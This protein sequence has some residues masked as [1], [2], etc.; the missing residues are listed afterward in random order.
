[1]QG[2]CVVRNVLR[3]HG[4]SCTGTNYCRSDCGHCD[5]TN[6]M[7]NIVKSLY[8]SISGFGTLN[9]FKKN[10]CV[11]CGE[12]SLCK[13]LLLR[14]RSGYLCPPCPRSR[15]CTQRRVIDS[16][17]ALPFPP[18][19]LDSALVVIR[20]MM[21]NAAVMV[22]VKQVPHHLGGSVRGALNYQAT[23]RL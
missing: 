12:E 23:M 16:P 22:L 3:V 4:L 20:L 14:A 2:S 19:V 18:A 11:F 13:T 7:P 21:K 6:G 1:M 10:P 8:C 15:E 9:V 17:R 5:A